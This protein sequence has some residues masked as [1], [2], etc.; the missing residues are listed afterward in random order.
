MAK[1]APF[2]FG[3]PTGRGMRALKDLDQGEALLR[4]PAPLLVTPR[5][6]RQ[7]LKK[8]I[9]RWC[10]QTTKLEQQQLGSSCGKLSSNLD[11]SPADFSSTAADN[12]SSTTS[13]DVNGTRNTM[14]V[15]VR[16][17]SDSV[18]SACRA[19]GIDEDNDT[20][21]LT[22]LGETL[23]VLEYDPSDDTVALESRA[24]RQTLWFPLQAL[25]K[26][27][28]LDSAL[29]AVSDENALVLAVLA[30]KKWRSSYIGGAASDVGKDAES[31]S[32]TSVFVA[33][34]DKSPLKIICGTNNMMCLL[35]EAAACPGLTR[36]IEEMPVATVGLPAEWTCAEIELLRASPRYEL[37]KKQREQVQEARHRCRGALS[38]FFSTVKMSTERVGGDINCSSGNIADESILDCLCGENF[39]EFLWA[40]TRVASRHRTRMAFRT[41]VP[42]IEGKTLMIPGGFDIFNHSVAVTPGCS[43]REAIVG[44]AL[45]EK[46]ATTLSSEGTLKSLE[47]TPS[48]TG[49]ESDVEDGEKGTREVQVI[50]HQVDGET[51]KFISR[52]REPD[53]EIRLLCQQPGGVKEGKEVFISYG[54]KSN[55]ELLLGYGFTIPDNA[56]HDFFEVLLDLQKFHLAKEGLAVPPAGGEVRV[57]L[58]MR[59]LQRGAESELLEYQSVPPTMY[60]D[61]DDGLH[62]PNR[63][64]RVVAKIKRRSYINAKSDGENIKDSTLL[65]KCAMP[66]EFLALA[67][68]EQLSDAELLTLSRTSSYPLHEA[69]LFSDLS[70]TTSAP[71]KSNTDNFALLRAELK[72]TRGFADHFRATLKRY[73]DSDI[74]HVGAPTSQQH[75]GRSVDPI[76]QQIAAT[77]L[78][79][80][81]EILEDSLRE[82]E[83]A[84]RAVLRTALPSMVAAIARKREDFM[85]I[86][87]GGP[88]S[89][90]AEERSK[91]EESRA[92]VARMRSDTSQL[93]SILLTSTNET[94]SCSASSTRTS[95]Y[96][97]SSVLTTNRCWSSV[98]DL[99]FRAAYGLE[100][101][102]EESLQTH[103]DAIFPKIPD[104]GAAQIEVEKNFIFSDYTKLHLEKTS[105]WG[106]WLFAQA[107]ACDGLLSQSDMSTMC[108]EAIDIRKKHA[109]SILPYEPEL[110]DKLLFSTLTRE[111]PSSQEEHDYQYVPMIELGAGR[112]LWAQTLHQRFHK[113]G[114]TTSGNNA[115]NMIRAFDL[116]AWDAKFAAKNQAGEPTTTTLQMDDDKPEQHIHR[117][118]SS[119][120]HRSEKASPLV[121]EVG[122]PDVLD[123]LFLDKNTHEG[124]NAGLMIQ[125]EQR[126]PKTLAL[127]WPDYE[128]KGTFGLECVRR[129]EGEFLFLVGEWGSCPGGK[130][131]TLT[132]SSHTQ[133]PPSY[134]YSCNGYL[135]LFPQYPRGQS[136]SVEFQD[137]VE[138]D[139]DIIHSF[140]LPHWPLARDVARIWKRRPQKSSSRRH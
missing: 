138:R 13:S 121:I 130:E 29:Q 58:A 82:C 62:P 25:Q 97:S 12:F 67:R 30:A 140:E 56:A 133:S 38:A 99:L 102:Q 117:E 63:C 123:G 76:R 88:R 6:C 77:L 115:S 21:R 14:W 109:W 96:P 50:A 34:N 71:M 64:P 48:T 51:S 85:Q 90:L 40:W 101:L 16:R 135:R 112:G 124:E 39:D 60:A 45:I 106:R 1:V 66:R 69:L 78:N 5:R 79:S 95:S 49:D 116:G 47:S 104:S 74:K 43:T 46:E 61:E 65:N 80:E 23:P 15:Q 52:T 94:D 107:L 83:D 127:M 93:F 73:E 18:L 33:K 2:D 103:V 137:L 111:R 113:G 35:D 86:E 132:F 128:A 139:F 9:Q 126:G 87:S 4:A 59:F 19:C 100:H 120:D 114:S 28:S 129:W 72:A 8:W 55:H 122:G 81:K 84:F 70:T 131:R 11:F 136:F 89:L 32:T 24:D 57:E 27:H 134:G 118:E 105:F 17:D 98:C 44:G 26:V 53:Y 110:F 125:D 31:T 22:C 20:A 108:M 119:D 10:P 68:L 42:E 41:A 91:L 7:V 54:A 92:K 75:E 37:A 3:P 36:L